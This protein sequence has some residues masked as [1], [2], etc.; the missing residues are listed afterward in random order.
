MRQATLHSLCSRCRAKVV[1]SQGPDRTLP[2]VLAWKYDSSRCISTTSTAND[3]DLNGRE[4]QIFSIPDGG[5]RVQGYVEYGP[6]D[7]APSVLLSRISRIASGGLSDRQ[8][9][10]P[11]RSPRH[12][13]GPAG[14]RALH[15][16]ATPPH[17]GLACGHPYIC[18][19]RAASA[20]CCSRRIQRRPRYAGVCVHC[21]T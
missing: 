17:H 3:M 15:V 11:S 13:A 21:C 16:P 9:R 6:L 12:L 2:A 19:A 7:G 5:G 14:L 10:L 20:L 1:V 18:A 8:T 4:S